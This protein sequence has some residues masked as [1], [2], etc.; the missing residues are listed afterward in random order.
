VTDLD[1]FETSRRLRIRQLWETPVPASSSAR[2]TPQGRCRRSTEST[3]PARELIARFAALGCGGHGECSGAFE[4]H[5][6]ACSPPQ[7]EKRI[8]IAARA[9]TEIGTLGE[10]TRIPGQLAPANPNPTFALL[11][12][13]R[14]RSGFRF[15]SR[16][17][18][19]S[20]NRHLQCFR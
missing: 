16:L 18:V 10:R 20:G 15:L 5:R 6:I 4:P 11:D 14:N 2:G 19:A 8:A 3:A 17:I 9:M 1:P 13:S 12:W 7:L